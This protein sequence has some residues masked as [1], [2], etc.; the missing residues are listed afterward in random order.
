MTRK[1]KEEEEEE[2]E[3]DARRGREGPFSFSKAVLVIPAL[4]RFHYSTPQS[5]QYRENCLYD[6]TIHPKGLMV[7]FQK[8]RKLPD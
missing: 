7:A 5:H 8:D 1:P 3:E 4:N 2:E 6:T